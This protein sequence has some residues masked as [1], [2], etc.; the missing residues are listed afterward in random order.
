MIKLLGAARAHKS[1]IDAVQCHR[2]DA[3][4]DIAP[5]PRQGKT[6]PYEYY[7]FGACLGCDLL[8]VT[9]A[10][11]RKVL[12]MVDQGNHGTAFQKLAV[13]RKET[14]PR[15][16]SVLCRTDGSRGEGS[17][18]ELLTDGST[19]AEYSSPFAIFCSSHGFAWRPGSPC[20]TPEVIGRVER[21]GGI[22]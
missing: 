12:N 21:H 11:G 13:I 1:Y 2:C 4:E 7:R 18:E 5:R 3:C 14:P 16:R 17:H 8:D 22:D 9:D 20:E 6:L 15:R 19:F 10:A